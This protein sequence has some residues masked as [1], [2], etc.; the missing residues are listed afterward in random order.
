MHVWYLIPTMM[1]LKCY[2][3][4]QHFLCTGNSF[5]YWIQTVVNETNPWPVCYVSV[6][7][8]FPVLDHLQCACVCI[9]FL[10]FCISPVFCHESSPNSVSE[11]SPVSVC[12]SPAVYLLP[13]TTHYYP[14]V[15]VCV[16]PVCALSH[17][18]HTCAT[19]FMHVSDCL[20][21]LPSTAYLCLSVYVCVWPVCALSHLQHTCVT[22]FMSV[23]DLCAPSPVFSSEEEEAPKQ[24]EW[25]AHGVCDI[26]P[27]SSLP[28]CVLHLT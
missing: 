15:Y 16:W 2:I 12:M 27:L 7:D 14:S 13:S 24:E 23:S 18:Q 11:P 26:P 21:P 4:Q 8:R 28:G 22:M 20:R 17:L 19:M 10:P 9:C 5:S 1:H 3:Q 25:V 6:S